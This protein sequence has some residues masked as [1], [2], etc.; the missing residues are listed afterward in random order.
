[1]VFIDD[2]FPAQ[3]GVSVTGGEGGESVGIHEEEQAAHTPCRTTLTYM[4]Q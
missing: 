2:G 4:I 3:E 1:M